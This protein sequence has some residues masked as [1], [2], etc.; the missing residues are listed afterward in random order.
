MSGEPSNATSGPD[1][2]EVCARFQFDLRD[3]LAA[4]VLAASALAAFGPCAIVFAA[5]LLALVVC[6]RA[7]RSRSRL[8]VYLGPFLLVTCLLLPAISHTREGARG[9]N[10]LNN[11]KLIG[12]GL[13]NYHV[14]HGC[15]PPAYV[16]DA[17]GKP[18]HS[19][20]VLIL[21]Y[22]ERRILYD[23][24]N[25][26]EPWNSPSNR[27]LAGHIPSEYTCPSDPGNHPPFTS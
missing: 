5:W 8:L 15:F 12:L 27:Y 25:F 22:M 3:L 10:C 23:S 16:A 9:A 2:G 17:D 1:R 21:P 6:V 18:M 14:E 24:Y 7:A 26:D 19:W 20:R 11:L 4:F 13:Q